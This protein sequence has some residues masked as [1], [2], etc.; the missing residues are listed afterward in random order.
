MLGMQATSSFLLW[1]T[2]VDACGADVTRQCVLDAIGDGLTGGLACGPSVDVETAVGEW[3]YYWPGPA[4]CPNN[5]T[6][7]DDDAGDL[8]GY[9]SAVRTLAA[10]ALWLTFIAWLVRQLPWSKGDDVPGGA[11]V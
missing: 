7:F 1:A 2:G 9:R 10:V 3:H 6:Q 11:L 5:G 4:G 8:W